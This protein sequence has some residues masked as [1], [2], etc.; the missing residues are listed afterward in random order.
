MYTPQSESEQQRSTSEDHVVAEP[1]SARKWASEPDRV[2]EQMRDDLTAG[3]FA[4][5][6]QLVESTL[7]E[8]YGASRTPVR[9]AITRLVSDRLVEARPHAVAIVRDITARDVRQIYEVRQALEGFAVESAAGMID[10]SQLQRLLDHYDAGSESEPSA[11]G[12][13]GKGVLPLHFLIAQ[14]LGNGR[15]TDLL[16]AESLPLVRMHSLYWR[17]AHP[18]VDAMS[19]VR[20]KAALEEHRTIAAALLAGSTSEARALV[21]AH[22]QAACDYLI[23]LMAAVDLD[24]VNVGAAQRGRDRQASGLDHMLPG[25]PATGGVG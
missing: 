14:S 15:L 4:P 18:R 16:F 24:P 7:A 6:E 23:S 22:L 2:Y 20:R 17:M 3:Q 9:S 10:R 5:R 12:R 19:L 13:D 25:S 11:P 8:R 1:A 21:A